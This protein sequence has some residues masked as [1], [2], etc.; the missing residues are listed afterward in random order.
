VLALRK[1]AANTHKITTRKRLH[2]AYQLETVACDKGVNGRWIGAWGGVRADGGEGRTLQ[3]WAMPGPQARRWCR[4]AMLECAA[5]P[6][7][8]RE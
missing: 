7:P 3:A 2:M 8:P 5:Y 6:P 1:K 4:R